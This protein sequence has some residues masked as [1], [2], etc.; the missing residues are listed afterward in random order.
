MGGRDDIVS[1]QLEEGFARP[2]LQLWERQ[3]TWIRSDTS[4][5]IVSGRL[6]IVALMSHI[7]LIDMDLHQ[8]FDRR[9]IR[10]SSSKVVR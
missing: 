2:L 9:R 5:R 1:A 10:R 4:M 3:G 7:C 6:N 8:S